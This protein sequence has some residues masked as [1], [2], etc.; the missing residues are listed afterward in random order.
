MADTNSKRISHEIEVLPSTFRKDN[1]QQIINDLSEEDTGLGFNKIIR[2][3][4]FVTS[5]ETWTQDPLTF[6]STAKLRTKIVYN[7][8][9]VFVNSIVKEIFDEETGTIVISTVTITFV[10]TGTNA[11]SSAAVGVTRP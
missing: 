7:R 10:R 8:T 3:G 9:G 4:V 1:L 2:T 6:P 11:V 5:T